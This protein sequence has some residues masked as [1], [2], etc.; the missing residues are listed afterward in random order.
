LVALGARDFVWPPT[1]AP[2]VGE[3]EGVTPTKNPPPPP[4]APLHYPLFSLSLLRSDVLGCSFLRRG[5]HMYAAVLCCAHPLPVPS[6]PFRREAA[7]PLQVRHPP[8]PMHAATISSSLSSAFLTQLSPV[9]TVARARILIL[10]FTLVWIA[11]FGSGIGY[12]VSCWILSGSQSLR[13]Q[14][15]Q[16]MAACQPVDECAALPADNHDLSVRI[17]KNLEV[18]A[19]IAPSSPSV[20]DA[21]NR[22]PRSSPMLSSSSPQ[23]SRAPRPSLFLPSSLPLS[24]IPAPLSHDAAAPPHTP[25]SQ[26]HRRGRPFSVDNHPP[27][28]PN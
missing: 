14:L 20:C 28:P 3:R 2:F 21:C 6:R 4:P 16:R 12:C 19:G 18:S 25:L 13:A 27:L 17:F 5:A 10:L 7:A 8:A 11:L 22:R 26:L 1:I 23:P 15:L 9:S 24:L